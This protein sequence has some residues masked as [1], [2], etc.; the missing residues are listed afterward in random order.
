MIY[1]FI[2]INN[3]ISSINVN[4]ETMSKVADFDVKN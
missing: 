3:Y 4:N 1:V 2:N